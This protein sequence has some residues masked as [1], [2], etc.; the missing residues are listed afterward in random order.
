[1][2]AALLEIGAV[3]R[4]LGISP[5][6]LRTWERRYR[7]VLPE[8][9]AHG[10]RLYSSDQVQILRRVLALTRTGLRARAAHSAA[11]GPQPLR[12]ARVELAA[13][14]DASQLAR[15]AVDEVLGQSVSEKFA[16][17][18][19]LVAT[20]LVQNAVLYG[21]DREPIE[22]EL[23]AF[24]D[25]VDLRVGNAGKRLTLKSLRSRR[26]QG[27]RGLE[28]VDALAEAWSIDT[29][30]FGTQIAVRVPKEPD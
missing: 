26:R 16:F 12:S 30:P 14:A 27:G 15:R 1:M 21:S 28:I 17:Y 18:V 5:S 23:K 10:E 9:G 2:G 25:W 8:R 24:S 22:I 7:I 4:E 20:E 11:V 29:G 19:R 6:T 13:S 3:A